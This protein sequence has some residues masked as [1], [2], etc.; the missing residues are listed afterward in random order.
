MH[1]VWKHR[2]WGSNPLSTNDGRPIR[3]ID[4]GLPNTDAGPDFFNA[5][6]EIGGKLWV[7]NVEIHVRASDWK[8]HGHDHDKAYD[9]VILHVVDKDDAPVY[10]SNGER[11]PQM[12][13]PCSPQFYERYEHLVNSISEIPCSAQ[14]KD[15]PGLVITE[16]VE[17]L[18]FERLHSKVRRLR[19]LLTTYNGSW[20][21]VCYVTLSRNLGFGINNDALE[22]L[23]RCTPLRLL[24]KHS[25]SLLQLEA[26]LFGQAG[27]LDESNQVNDHYFLQ[28]QREYAFLANKFSL[29]PIERE[30]WKMFRIRPQNFPYKRIAL[31]AQFVAGGFNMM[32]KILDANGDEKTLRELFNV[33]L[34]GYWAE[35]FT[36]GE[37]SQASQALSDRSTDIILIN[38]VA[39][40]YYAYGE[41]TDDYEMTDCAIGLLEQLKPERNSIVDKFVFAGIECSDAL[42]SQ[43]L[44]QLKCEYCDAKKCIYCKIG[45]RL[46]SAA[47]LKPQQITGAAVKPQ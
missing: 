1:Y 42:T 38:T 12:V 44:I 9:N 15:V 24:H 11:I 27:L 26:L 47:A 16:W 5:K 28:L 37:P 40:L 6:V 19:E 4:T 35:H 13:M 43:A 32:A 34:S 29:K 7:G 10:R 41:L 39:P 36:F 46:L 14:I 31:L 2:L 17:A 45:H 30:A 20:E 21:D 3:V 8:R 25:D 33:K 18:A 22:R 23:A